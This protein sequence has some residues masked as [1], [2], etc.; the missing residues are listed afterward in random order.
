MLLISYVILEKLLNLSVLQFPLLL[1]EIIIVSPVIRIKWDKNTK[2]QAQVN[3]INVSQCITM[4]TA[5]YTILFIYT[6]QLLAL[7]WVVDF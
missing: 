5:N 1:N 2:C 4:D 3:K 6:Q 7:G